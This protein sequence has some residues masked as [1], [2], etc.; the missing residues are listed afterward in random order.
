[1][2]GSLSVPW[3]REDNDGLSIITSILP[4]D[5]LTFAGM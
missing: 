2:I 5:V 4:Q 3:G 1:M